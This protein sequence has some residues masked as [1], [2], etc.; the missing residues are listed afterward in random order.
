MDRWPDGGC[1]GGQ[2]SSSLTGDEASSISSLDSRMS[3]SAGA[4]C[5]SI[6]TMACTSEDMPEEDFEDEEGDAVRKRKQWTTEED[7][8]VRRCV[9]IYGT[10]AWT[11]VAQD[12]PGRTGKQCRERWHN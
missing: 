11:L 12:L 6:S 10:R 3:L 2:P 9:G 8:L 7:E 4:S 5:S 1:F